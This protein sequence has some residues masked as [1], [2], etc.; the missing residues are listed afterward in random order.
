MSL[1]QV[2]SYLKRCVYI[3]D[4]FIHGAVM[5]KIQLPAMLQRLPWV[6]LETGRE[7]SLQMGVAEQAVTR[8]AVG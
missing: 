5:G 6:W 2:T 4:C 3:L 1:N 7:R 8:Q